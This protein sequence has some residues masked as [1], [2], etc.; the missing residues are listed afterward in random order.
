[1]DCIRTG[2]LIRQLRAEKGFTQKEIA[3]RLNISDKA[4]SKWERGCGCPDISLVNELAELFEVS[5][6]TLLSGSIEENEKTGG[7]M[8]KTLFYFCPECG[9]ITASTGNTDIVCCGRKLQALVPQESDD[10]H[11]PEITEVEDEYYITLPHPMTKEHYIVFTAYVT[12]SCCFIMRHYPEQDPSFRFP[13]MHNGCFYFL[14]S[15]DGL[16]RF[17]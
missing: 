2:Q 12:D 16:F 11:T 15:K 6:E 13:H 3:D 7:N 14:C 8:K 1:M 5:A 4:V 9:N 17:K 10:I